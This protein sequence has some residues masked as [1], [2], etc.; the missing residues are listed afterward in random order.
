MLLLGG[1]EPGAVGA[2]LAGGARV[3]GPTTVAAQLPVAVGAYVLRATSVAASSFTQALGSAAVAVVGGPGSQHC[4]C[5]WFCLLSL[6]YSC[7]KNPMDRGAWWAVVHGV[8]EL[9]TAE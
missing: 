5:P 6:E 1:G 9:G 7:L 4:L 3:M 2:A 8:T